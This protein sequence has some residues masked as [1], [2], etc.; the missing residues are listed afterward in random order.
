ML[1]LMAPT[2]STDQSTALAPPPRPARPTRPTRIVLYDGV[3]G[4]CNRTV[5]FL[6]RVDRQRA[7]VFAPLQGETAAALRARH[8]EIPDD[9]DTV[10]Y[11]EDERVYLRSRVFV[12]AARHLPYPWKLG[13][14]LWIVPWP[15]ADLLYRLIAR[16]RYRVF[17]KY[18]ACRV[19]DPEQR[20]RFLP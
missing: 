2:P 4:L 9:L 20:A 3:C 11:V 14:W 17:G 15:L 18:D 8:P 12:R 1:V 16:I 13:R 7:L 19:P 6:L 5:Q 10:V